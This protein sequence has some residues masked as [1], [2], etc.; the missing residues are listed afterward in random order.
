MYIS[1]G[2]PPSSLLPSPQPTFAGAR[3]NTH[4]AIACQDPS[5]QWYFDLAKR[6]PVLNKKEMTALGQAQM[7]GNQATQSLRKIDLGQVQA[8]AEKIAALKQ[9]VKAGNHARREI[10]EH[11]LLLVP[12]F[13]NSYLKTRT[14]DL[15][16]AELLTAGNDGL[17]LAAH[18]FDPSKGAFGTVA[19]RRIIGEI[20]TYIGKN[21]P[22]LNGNRLNI[23]SL[24]EDPNED[25]DHPSLQEKLTDPRPGPDA[26]V[27]K[28]Q[29]DV[30]L[31]Q[32]LKTL[33]L[34]VQ[35]LLRGYYG[36]GRQAELTQEV[37]G[38]MTGAGGKMNVSHLLTLGRNTLRNSEK[39]QQLRDALDALNE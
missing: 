39:S 5:L 11:N 37:L 31:Q 20:Q 38:Q 28:E 7:A 17:M 35:S 23:L 12:Y 29:L 1:A 33:P 22:T 15:P 6:K 24:S 16:Y 18:T 14:I 27:Q 32:A 8:S 2:L 34:R 26:H 4:F 25:E 19:G 21:T 9:Q 3:K 13:L 10:I 30:L 36:L